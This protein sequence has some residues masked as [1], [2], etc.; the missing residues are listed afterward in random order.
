MKILLAGDTHCNTQGLVRV[1]EH[2]AD[3][4]IECVFVLGDFGIWEHRDAGR[5]FLDIVSATAH[6]HDIDVHFLDG[7]H[8]N[9]PML[10]SMYGDGRARQERVRPNL[11]YH[12]RGQRWEW[13]GVKIMSL[14]GGASIDKDRRKI[15]ESW[16]PTE[17]I[18]DE[19]VTYAIRGGESDVDVLLCHDAPQGLDHVFV[20]D[21]P[22]FK[23]R[24]A[25]S[26]HNRALLQR[27]IN[28]TRPTHVFHGHMHISHLTPVDYGWG[29]RCLVRGLSNVDDHGLAATYV[30]ELEDGQVVR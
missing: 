28:I 22:Y 30:L 23:M 18:T 26:T 11:Y 24:H 20:V 13:A 5:A 6:A 3:L 14:G 9:H 19:D 7:N 10:W 17:L 25:A 29:E 2:A 4:K 16:W 12:G 8:D 1:I 21:N 15:W 27:V